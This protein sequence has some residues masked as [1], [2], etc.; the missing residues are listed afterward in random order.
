[1]RVKFY[2]EL[3]TITIREKDSNGRDIR[4]NIINNCVIYWS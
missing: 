2:D 3:E 4:Y 1:M